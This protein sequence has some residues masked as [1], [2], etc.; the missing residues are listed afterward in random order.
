MEDNDNRSNPGGPDGCR[1]SVELPA[2]VAQG[3]YS[4]LVFISHSSSEFVLDFIRVLPGMPQAKVQSRVLLAPEHA[5]RLLL[6]LQDN[7]LKHERTFG[8]INL[9]G[10]QPL[11]PLPMVKGE[12]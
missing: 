9:P 1:L 6:A 5:K 4:N 8:P 7:I 10:E 12:A 3:V 11:P 2:D